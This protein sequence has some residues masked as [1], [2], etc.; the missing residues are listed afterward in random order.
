[1]EMP[2]SGEQLKCGNNHSYTAAV[3]KINVVKRHGRSPSKAGATALII[4]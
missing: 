4:C 2:F 1:M 3:R